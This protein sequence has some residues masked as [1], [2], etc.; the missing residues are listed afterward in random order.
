MLRV[1]GRHFSSS[2]SSN[3]LQKY[4]IFDTSK[5]NYTKIKNVTSRGGYMVNEIERTKP[6]M[7]AQGY[8]FSWNVTPLELFQPEAYEYL[9]VVRPIPGKFHETKRMRRDLCDR[10][11]E[12]HGGCTK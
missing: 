11:R 12:R 4:N 9:R 1:F 5:L 6:F 2:K 10:N 7:I 8:V 3:P